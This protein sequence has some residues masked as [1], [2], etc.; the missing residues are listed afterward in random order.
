MFASDAF[1]E[2]QNSKHEARTGSKILK[3][4]LSI[5]KRY[6][7]IYRYFLDI[8]YDDILVFVIDMCS[9]AALVCFSRFRC[10]S[11][12]HLL[13]L[14]DFERKLPLEVTRW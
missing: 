7:N 13:E 11:C 3:V 1:M 5:T 6:S 2:G 9:S 14:W 8:I 4:L 10:S 12:L